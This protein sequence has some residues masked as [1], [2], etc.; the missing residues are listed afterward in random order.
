[1]AP[2][3][4]QSASA[5]DVSFS[6]VPGSIGRVTLADIPQAPRATPASDRARREALA[7]LHPILNKFK[8][9]QQRERVPVDTAV[10]HSARE[11]FWS[12]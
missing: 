6:V 1:M 10:Y 3:E 8:T 5:E 7:A 9:R 12:K 11:T 4:F 2:T